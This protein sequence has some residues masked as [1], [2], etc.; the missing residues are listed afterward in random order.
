MF[1]FT[2]EELVLA[3]TKFSEAV[4]VLVEYATQCGMYLKL[5]QD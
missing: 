4:D 2:G 3:K 5:H 1:D